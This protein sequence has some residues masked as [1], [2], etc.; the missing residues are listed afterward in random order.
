MKDREIQIRYKD[1]NLARPNLCHNFDFFFLIN[2]LWLSIN[3]A[4]NFLIT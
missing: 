3:S 1:D 2:F 4:L